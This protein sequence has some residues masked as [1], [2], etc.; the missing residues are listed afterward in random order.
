MSL[1]DIERIVI[2]SALQRS[3]GN[4]AEAARSLGVT[5][6]TMRYRIQKY[7]LEI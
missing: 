1:D 6:Q 7:G 4:V 3:D 2:E 5:R